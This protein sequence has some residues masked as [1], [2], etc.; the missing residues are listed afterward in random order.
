M[1]PPFPYEGE[2][3][4]VR[5]KDC[6]RDGWTLTL[7]RERRNTREVNE[8]LPIQILKIRPQHVKVKQ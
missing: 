4:E 1:K 6:S 3:T 7:R 8:S 2:R 5:G